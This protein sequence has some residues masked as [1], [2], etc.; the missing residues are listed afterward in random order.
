MA[1]FDKA[2]FQVFSPILGRSLESSNSSQSL[3]MG[4]P[5]QV[6][7][8]GRTR[9]AQDNLAHS[10]LWLHHNR[11]PPRHSSPEDEAMPW[12][13]A[14]ESLCHL[15][16]LPRSSSAVLLAP[17]LT[18]DSKGSTARK[19]WEY[20]TPFHIPPNAS[21]VCPTHCHSTVPGSRRTHQPKQGLV[22]KVG[23]VSLSNE[24]S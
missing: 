11:D 15:P 10:I 3:R 8:E 21:P 2:L 24:C 19:G 4:E 13:Q 20:P 23:S 5:T 6:L 12:H 18:T 14:T 22:D 7:L 9:T 16:Q 1:T 17:A